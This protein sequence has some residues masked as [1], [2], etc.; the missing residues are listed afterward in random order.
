[1][2]TT[3]YDVAKAA[4]VSIATVSKVINNTGK[5]RESTRLKVL[6]TMKEL[7]YK[8]NVVATAL[9]G[10]STNTLGL[11]VPDISNP[12]FS[13]MARTIEDRAHEQGMS[14]IMCSTDENLEKEKKYLELLQ[15]KQVD[16]FIVASSFKD[17]E[18]LKELIQNKIPL[19][20]LTED[21][22]ALGVTTVSVDDY[23]GG[24]EAASYL[25]SSGHKDIAI[26]AEKVQSSRMRIHGY[27]D[28]HDAAG[29]SYS[30]D[31][32]LRTTASIENGKSCF[33]SLYD[34]G[35]VPTAIFAC[36]DLIAIGVIRGAKEK[37]LYVPED[38][39]VIGFDD[40]ILS[41][42]TVPALTTVAQ[43]IAE[44]GKK[45]VDVIV[46]EVKGHKKLGE[47]VLFTPRLIVR[48]TT[49]LLENKDLA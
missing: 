5:M 15:R 35:R 46:E 16:G 19:V 6:K 13:E 27:R 21:D 33:E 34:N 17:K 26:I 20:M 25:L 12:F 42:T 14:V 38:L 29:V 31:L 45:V 48:E 49:S 32:I 11:L 28:A 44:M 47:R 4:E 10:K 1:M 41:T 18:L 37:G 36:N 7:N 2:K 43:P 9:T 39:S 3:I 22:P 8:P 24:F 23:K 30:E 40:T